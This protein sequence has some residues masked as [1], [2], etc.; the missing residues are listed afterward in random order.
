MANATPSLLRPLAIPGL[1]HNP[2][3]ANF[4][5]SGYIYNTLPDDAD[6]PQ[7]PEELINELKSLIKA[8]GV[9]NKFGFHLIHGHS[10]IDKGMAMVGKPML[11]LPGHWT[12]PMRVDR[13]QLEALRGYV[14]V[15]GMDGE[16]HPYEYR[17]GIIPPI[18]DSDNAFIA[19]T[20]IYFNLRGLTGLIGLELLEQDMRGK[21]MK[22]FVLSD[23]D[24]T[25][26]VP[27]DAVNPTE[28]YRTTGWNAVEGIKDLKGNATGHAKTTRGT[29][30]VFID[31]KG[32]PDGPDDMDAEK[33]ILEGLRQG[34]IID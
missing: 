17:Q 4:E 28:D 20:Q 11:S 14:F 34:G 8:F 10:K 25:V 32:L 3:R 26:M 12:R 1:H 24:G 33:V 29:H 31:G 6:Q 9:Q 7:V 19:A 2:T 18:T 27:A 22:E 13:L 23:C 5:M 30:Q 15:L 21:Y 16:F